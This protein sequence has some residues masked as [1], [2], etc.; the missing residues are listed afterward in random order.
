MFKKMLSALVSAFLL[1]L[2]LALLNYTPVSDR[3]AHHGY[4]SFTGLLIIYLLFATPVFL[5]GSIPVSYL[6][7]RLNQ[8]MT[9]QQRYVKNLAFYMIAGLMVGLLFLVIISEAGNVEHGFNYMSFSVLSMMG[10][11]LFFHVTTMFDKFFV[12]KNTSL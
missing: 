4:E 1:S 6:I 3:L 11:I 7:D 10:A 12:S 8:K 9:G 2:T 5:L